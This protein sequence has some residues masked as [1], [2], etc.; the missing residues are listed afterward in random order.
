MDKMNGYSFLG[1][2]TLIWVF[3]EIYYT[4]FTALIKPKSN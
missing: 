1:K 2:F 3:V 4:H